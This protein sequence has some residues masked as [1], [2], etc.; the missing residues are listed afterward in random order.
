MIPFIPNSFGDIVTAANLVWAIYTALR[1]TKGAAEDFQS[2]IQELKSFHH[3]LNLV[4]IIV[5]K[6]SPKET[7]AK[8]ILAEILRKLGDG[9]MRSS[10][11]SSSWHKIGWSVF[12]RQDIANIRSKVSRHQQ[13]I[14]MYLNGA[15]ISLNKDIIE[16]LANIQ[17]TV[18]EI[19]KTQRNIPQ[20]V[21]YGVAN[22]LTL[23]TTL[24]T[25]I[26]LPFEHCYTPED[27]HKFLLFY[28]RGKSGYIFVETH[29]YIIS[30]NSK[31]SVVIVKPDQWKAFMTRGARVVMSVVKIVRLKN[32]DLVDFRSVVV[33]IASQRLNTIYEMP[34]PAL[35]TDIVSLYFTIDT[36]PPSP[37]GW[38]YWQE[39][40]YATRRL[41][42]R[43]KKETETWK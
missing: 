37:D 1:E 15:G 17:T 18:A 26:T 3:A 11:Y 43:G 31:A 14:E 38:L 39:E 13:I 16:S 22:S 40:S 5:S 41:K 4:Y 9:N 20:P 2:L 19:Y 35:D 28:F 25:E 29:N 36:L 42:I 24:G 30:R 8:C 21:K 33:E 6:V 7:M 27:L 12:K 23:I 32:S 10:W 34:K